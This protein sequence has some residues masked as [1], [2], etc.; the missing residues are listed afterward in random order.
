[1]ITRLGVVDHINTRTIENLYAADLAYLQDFY[2][3]VNSS[4]HTRLQVTCPHCDGDFDVEVA[5]LGE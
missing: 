1:V 5:S 4:G 2:Q 3:R